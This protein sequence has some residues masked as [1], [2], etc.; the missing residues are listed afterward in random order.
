MGNFESSLFSNL[1]QLKEVNELWQEFQSTLERYPELEEGEF[2]LDSYNKF[3][4]YVMGIGFQQIDKVLLALAGELNITLEELKA[5]LKQYKEAREIYD[6]LTHDLSSPFAS[7]KGLILNIDMMASTLGKKFIT[8][9]LP[10]IEARISTFFS[11]VDNFNFDVSLPVDAIATLEVVGKSFK[12]VN[13]NTDFQPL[14]ADVEILKSLELPISRGKFYFGIKEFITNALKHERT[15]VKLEVTISLSIL[16]NKYLI[17]SVADNGTGITEQKSRSVNENLALGMASEPEEGRD[18]SRGYGT[19]QLVSDTTKL[20]LSPNP[21]G[22]TTA[23][24]TIELT[25]GPFT[26]S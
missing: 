26:H 2:I 13:I 10:S 9:T 16:N 5:N 20:T 21:Q 11:G 24:W 19:S 12:G 1:Q 17:V 8:D 14:G 23:M 15:D 25:K 7:L 3:E 18:D 6:I 22:G 4:E